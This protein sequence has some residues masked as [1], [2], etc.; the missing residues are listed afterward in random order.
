MTRAVALIA[1][2]LVAAPALAAKPTVAILYFDYDKDDDLAQLK[3]GLAQMLISDLAGHE[4][5]TLVERARLQDVLAELQ[6]AQSRK[7]DPETAVKVGKLLNAQYI[8]MGA[9]FQALGQLQLTARLVEVETS[10]TVAGAKARGKPEDFFAL[11]QELS[12]QLSTAL[13]EKISAA[14]SP[15]GAEVRRPKKPSKLPLEQ[16][17]R[18]GKALEALDKKDKEGAKKELLAVTKAQPDFELAALDLA[19]MMK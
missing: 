1:G 15:S 18:Y 7:V 3:K 9:Y 8:V 4:K 14:A 2:L 17:V 10:K 5:V 19:T 11:E 13:S 12:G 6:L 16:A